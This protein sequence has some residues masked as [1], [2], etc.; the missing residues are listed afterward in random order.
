MH[1]NTYHYE[2]GCVV[3]AE[4]DLDNPP[5]LGIRSD[6]TF[7]EVVGVCNKHTG[8]TG[9]AIYDNCFEESTRLIKVAKD[10][11]ANFNQVNLNDIDLYAGT[12]DFKNGISFSYQWIGSDDTRTLQITVNGMTI[13]LAQK[14]QLQTLLNGKYGIGKVLIT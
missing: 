2:C 14:L 6:Y 7:K 13:T 10:F 11:V 5:V 12:L 1:A 9:N 4:H 8:L 3:V